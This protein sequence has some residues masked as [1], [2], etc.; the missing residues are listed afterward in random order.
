VEAILA[1]I[2]AWIGR[3]WVQYVNGLTILDS[4]DLM[5]NAH[6]SNAGQIKYA[7]KVLDVL[8]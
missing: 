6:P 3:A 8:S 5:D 1:K 2:T 4:A 7:D